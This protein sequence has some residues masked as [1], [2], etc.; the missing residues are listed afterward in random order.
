MKY[1]LFLCTIL[2]VMVSGQIIAQSTYS[3]T[4][5]VSGTNQ[6]ITF[7]ITPID[8]TVSYG[9]SVHDKKINY[10]V[11][12]KLVVTTQN[13]PNG[14]TLDQVYITFENG[15]NATD[16]K[17]SP[18]NE[19]NLTTPFASNPL[20]INLGTSQTAN[21]SGTYL[22][23]LSDQ[24]TAHNTSILPLVHYTVA[25]LKF[26]L[27]NNQG[28]NSSYQILTFDNY[29]PNSGENIP[30][31]QILPITLSQFNAKL[32]NQAILLNW[33]TSTEINNNYFVV[34]RSFDGRKF[35]SLTY[36][37]G[38][39]NSS[40]TNN[41]SYRDYTYSSQINYYRLKQV[42]YDGAST[43]YNV[44]SLDASNTTSNN[45]KALKIFPNPG[46]GNI[47]IDG[48]YKNIVNVSVYNISGA[49]VATQT[50]S[51]NKLSLPSPL[52]SGM[53]FINMTDRNN[54][55]YSLKYILSK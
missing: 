9:G 43:Y 33:T 44:V 10:D 13:I 28:S 32:D 55:H 34:E 40:S 52:P 46:N 53:Y 20:T 54:K 30:S 26:R 15:Q 23:Q 17:Y 42:D 6:T 3:K 21:I 22:S 38:V 49:L 8:A 41:Y 31:T 19:T 29:D 51:S 14:T 50:L 18:T 12:F 47:T 2:F 24:N 1:K 36:I 7:Q 39:G 5:T 27:T 25:N 37:K 35:D 4:F 48:D 16:A 11:N 45:S